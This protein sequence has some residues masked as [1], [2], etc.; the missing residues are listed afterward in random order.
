MVA[1]RVLILS[2]ILGSFI[3][4]SCDSRQ[5]NPVDTYV[6]AVKNAGE[7]SKTASLDAVRQ[8]IVAYHAANGKYPESLQD[9]EDM[10]GSR[11]DVSRYNYDPQTGTV[12]LKTQE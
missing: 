8:S 3:L 11:L 10:V 9:V 5:A 12:T 2:V 1:K 4:T 6:G 7:V